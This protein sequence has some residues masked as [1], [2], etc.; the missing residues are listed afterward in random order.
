MEDELRW[1]G[2]KMEKR[3]VD[4]PALTVTDK[5]DLDG[6]GLKY[7]FS[8]GKRSIVAFTTAATLEPDVHVVKLWMEAR[9]P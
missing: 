7:S 6:S 2:A 8:N 3:G 4:Y 1:R 5:A 9:K